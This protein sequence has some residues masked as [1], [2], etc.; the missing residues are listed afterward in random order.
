MSNTVHVIV[1]MPKELHEDFATRAREEERSFSEQV[2]HALRLY[3]NG[4]T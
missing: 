3:L 2:S 4:D 1:R